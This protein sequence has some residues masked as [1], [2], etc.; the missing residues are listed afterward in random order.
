MQQNQNAIPC[1][2]RGGTKQ[3]YSPREPTRA[4]ADLSVAG[5]H[6]DAPHPEIPWS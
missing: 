1:A 5:P 4:G 2:Q 3:H 6:D